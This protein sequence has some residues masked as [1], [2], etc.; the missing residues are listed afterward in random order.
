MWWR[1]EAVPRWPAWWSA[2][3]SWRRCAS[4]GARML[5]PQLE[6]FGALEARWSALGPLADTQSLAMVPPIAKQTPYVAAA[7]VAAL[8]SISTGISTSCNSISCGNAAGS[9]TIVPYLTL[10]CRRNYIQ[11]EGAE[12]LGEAL[13]RRDRGLQV[14]GLQ[15]CLRRPFGCRSC[16]L[17]RHARHIPAARTVLQPALHTRSCI[18]FPAGPPCRAGAG[19]RSERQRPGPLL[20]EPLALCPQCSSLSSL[21]PVALCSAG[22]ACG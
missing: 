15:S 16:V 6:A 3:P 17:T 1:R 10:C 22:S 21:F 5:A 13:R 20:R 14:G 11:R 9:T 8:C 7:A 12:A 19:H 18:N 4:G 2:C